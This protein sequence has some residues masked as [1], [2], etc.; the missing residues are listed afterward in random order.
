M[1]RYTINEDLL[2]LPDTITLCE[3]SSRVI[4]YIAGFVVRHLEK[5][6]RSETCIDALTH[7][8]KKIWIECKAPAVWNLR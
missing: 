1:W 3:F 4:A 2:S 5:V 6:I 7:G 8:P